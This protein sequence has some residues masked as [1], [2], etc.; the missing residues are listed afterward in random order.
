MDTNLTGIFS[1]GDTRGI[2]E[3]VEKQVGSAA[4]MKSDMAD[5]RR[6]LS[7]IRKT[8]D[9]MHKKTDRI[10]HTLKTGTD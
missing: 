10:E 9:L 3:W 2:E 5:I 6:E 8:V 4:D 1:K 7:Q